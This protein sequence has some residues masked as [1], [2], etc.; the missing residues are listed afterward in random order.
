[1]PLADS[2]PQLTST[3]PG[4][5]RAPDALEFV[6]DDTLSPA[7]EAAHRRAPLSPEIGT[8]DLP[9]SEAM[10][11]PADRQRGDA[12]KPEAMPFTHTENGLD[13]LAFDD[14][15]AKAWFADDENLMD[16]MR[17]VRAQV[18]E[19]L[20]WKLNDTI[21]QAGRELLETLG[22]D[23]TATTRLMIAE[24]TAEDTP[25]PWIAHAAE[26]TDKAGDAPWDAESGRNAIAKFAFLVWDTLTHPAFIALVMLFIGFRSL[27]ALVRLTRRSRPRKSRRSRTN[28]EPPQEKP[29]SHSKHWTRRR[30]IR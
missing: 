25:P 26:R 9:T 28:V 29:R 8:A 1:M 20:D 5:H 23:D 30:R 2:A 14:P 19:L 13:D 22:I 12:K 10:I 16:R 21:N 17:N 18:A 11:S 24:R 3:V 4:A 27:V 15:G 7:L 6:T